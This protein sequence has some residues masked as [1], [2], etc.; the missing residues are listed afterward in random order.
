[1]NPTILKGILKLVKVHDDHEPGAAT[2]KSAS[3]ANL[4]QFSAAGRQAH[5]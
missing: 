3:V 4:Q 2:L 1:M 5:A